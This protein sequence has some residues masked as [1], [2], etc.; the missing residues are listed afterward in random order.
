MA[1]EASPPTLR[2]YIL[3]LLRESGPEEAVTLVVRLRDK[4]PSVSEELAGE[5]IWGLI[6]THQL[7]LTDRAEL[8]EA[9]AK[10]G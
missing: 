3:S 6:D 2:D 9:E 7:R 5:V 1:G 4:Y 8:E 10:T